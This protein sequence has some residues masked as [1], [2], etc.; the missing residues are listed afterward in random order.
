MDWL[1]CN[2]SINTEV[3]KVRVSRVEGY[4]E[5]MDIIKEYEDIIK[6]N[7]KNIIT[8]QSKVSTR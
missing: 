3:L 4:E 1:V 6:T 2:E 8:R 7:K 5:T